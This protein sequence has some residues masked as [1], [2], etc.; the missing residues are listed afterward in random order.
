MLQLADDLAAKE[1]EAFDHPNP[2]KPRT[3]VKQAAVR[4]QEVLPDK[5]T[6]KNQGENNS[7]K[8][9]MSRASETSSNRSAP[10]LVAG[11][12]AVKP[13]KTAVKP[14]KD[15]N[16]KYNKQTAENGRSDSH[17]FNNQSKSSAK[18]KLSKNFNAS[19]SSSSSRYERAG[20]QS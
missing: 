16:S 5:K 17:N 6:T 15:S 12:T 2:R 8:K 3:V 20:K 11:Q 18:L 4:N 9:N 13:D 7:S 19:Q 10:Q 1:T 14:D